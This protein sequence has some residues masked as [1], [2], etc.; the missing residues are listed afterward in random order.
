MFQII[1]PSEPMIHT[2]LASQ[3]NR[4]VS[5]A[6]V[7]SSRGTPPAGYTVDHHRVKLGV[8]A[9]VFETASAALRGWRMFQLGWVEL[10]WDSAPIEVG[11]DVAVLV[12]VFRVW[13][14]NACRVVY[15][16]DE[17]A[18]V[19]RYGFA[20]G[21]LPDHAES[22]EERFSIEWHRDDDSVWY[23]VLAFSR[24]HQPLARIGYPLTRRLQ[25]RFA[26]DSMAAMVR[27]VRL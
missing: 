24:P 23:D 25:K 8:G 9:N 27:S 16:L 15:L 2:F 11:S 17:P 21:T 3:R 5:Y 13:S 22:G 6:E 10:F 20:Y 14:L 1:R 12:R 26:R 18:P 7:G 19:R 4:D